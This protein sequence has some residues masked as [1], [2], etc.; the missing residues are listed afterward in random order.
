MSYSD[1]PVWVQVATGVLVLLGAVLALIGSSGMVRMP[2]FFQRVH[3]TTLGATMGAWA[4]AIATVLYFSFY[5]KTLV[6]HSLLV[7][8]FLAMTIPVTTLFL[9]RATLFRRRLA[10]DPE[11]PPSLGAGE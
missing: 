4:L 7:P 5:E 9:M 3:A 8:L 11:V 6:V 10:K 1:V 2:T